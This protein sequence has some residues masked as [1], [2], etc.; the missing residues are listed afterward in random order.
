MYVTESPTNLTSLCLFV[1]SHRYQ[2]RMTSLLFGESDAIIRW[3]VPAQ[4]MAGTY[5][6]RHFGSAKSVT[7][8]VKPFDGKT[9]EFF[10]KM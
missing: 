10:V 3:D 4:Q 1:L 8:S 2:W 6:I 7:G 5:R 9:R